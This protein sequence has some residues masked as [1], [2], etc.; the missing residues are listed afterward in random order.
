MRQSVKRTA[1][2]ALAACGIDVSRRG[3]V[4]RSLREVLSQVSGRG[5]EPATV[6]DVGVAFG[7][8]EL[9]EAFPRARHLLVE[10]IAEYEGALRELADRHGAEYVL[11]AAGAEPGTTRLNVHRVPACSSTLGERRGDRVQGEPREVPVVRIDDL[12]EERDLPPPYLIKV[13]VEGAELEVLAGAARIIERTEVVLLE[14]SLF[15]FWPDAPQ[16]HDLV[17]FM[18]ERGFVVYDIFGGHL[19]PVDGALA[20]VDLAFARED[21]PLR[22]E[23]RYAT[24]EQADQLY[25]SWGL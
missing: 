14:A 6:I 17:A 8:F 10:P 3:S 25:R 5:V 22:R 16:L 21:G 13:D 2:R 23:H 15:Q 11:A 18:K 9:Y 24:E 7:T 19:R 20:Q 4:P 12:C 1:K